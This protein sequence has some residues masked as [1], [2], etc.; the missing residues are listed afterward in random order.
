MRYGIITPLLP[1]WPEVF[2]KFSGAGGQFQ[3]YNVTNRA[4]ISKIDWEA[5][6]DVLQ[7]FTH[8]SWV[9]SGFF[10]VADLQGELLAPH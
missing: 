5:I 10:V 8:F 6:S 7:A 4:R 9:E 2:L 1:S 3:R